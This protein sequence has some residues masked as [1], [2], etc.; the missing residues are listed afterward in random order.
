MDM[1]EQKWLVFTSEN[2]SIV[3]PNEFMKMLGKSRKNEHFYEWKWD[4]KVI[5][6]YKWWWKMACIYDW[7][8][9]ENHEKW[10][11]KNQNI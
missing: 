6:K 2:I 1:A 8:F 11:I 10:M 7:E 3:I 9:I 4:K 5:C